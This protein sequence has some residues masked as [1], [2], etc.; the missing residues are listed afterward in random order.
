MK[1][2][3]LFLLGFVIMSNIL[4]FC[5]DAN[6]TVKNEFSVSKLLQKYEYFKD[7]SSAIDNKRAN[8]LLYETQLSAIKDHSSFQYQQ[9]Q[10]ELMGIIAIHNNLCAEYN[11]AMSKFNYAFCNKGSLP[12]S[13]LEPLPREYK[14]YIT[15]INQ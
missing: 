7:L 1:N 10:T 9:M 14:P 11:S 3:L 6:K 12:N 5:N 4:Y 2:F 8:I 15:D 13:N